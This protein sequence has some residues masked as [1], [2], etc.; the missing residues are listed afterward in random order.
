V[1]RAGAGGCVVA[2]E[3]ISP[4]LPEESHRVACT[5]RGGRHLAYRWGVRPLVAVVVIDEHDK[6]VYTEQVP[7]I[8]QEP[9]YAKALAA[10]GINIAG[11]EVL[12][13]PEQVKTFVDA[14]PDAGAKMDTVNLDV[15]ADQRVNIRRRPRSGRGYGTNWY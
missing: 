2:G 6:V 11:M 5:G 9:D 1:A 12:I 4:L 10:A 8:A 3:V 15:E 14:L 7:E 13:T